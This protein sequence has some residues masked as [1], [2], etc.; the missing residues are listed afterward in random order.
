MSWTLLSLDSIQSTFLKFFRCSQFLSFKV[1]ENKVAKCLG[2]ADW[3][4][5][6][7]KRFPNKSNST[8]LNSSE[9]GV[10]FEHNLMDWVRLAM[11]NLYEASPSKQVFL[12]LFYNLFSNR[13]PIYKPS[14]AVK[15]TEQNRTKLLLFPRAYSEIVV[16]F[17]F[18]ANLQLRKDNSKGYVLSLIHIWRCRRAI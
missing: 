18:L 4:V 12:A 16:S 5:F 9:H 2:S 8:E 7:V 10:P 6:V 1:S 17:P 14:T 15:K 13:N 11:V 3:V